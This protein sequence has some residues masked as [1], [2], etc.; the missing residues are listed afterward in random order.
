MSISPDAARL[1]KSCFCL[2]LDHKSLCAALEHEADDP[3]FCRRH[4]SARNNLFS[5]VPF[6]L[7]AE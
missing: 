5:N 4:V 1:N 6:F 2:T 7:P 3:D